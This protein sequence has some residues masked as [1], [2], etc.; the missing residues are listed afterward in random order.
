MVGVVVQ[1]VSIGTLAKELDRNFVVP[2]LGKARHIVINL[3]LFLWGW[4]RVRLSEA[5]KSLQLYTLFH[6]SHNV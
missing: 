2:T 5:L 6:L 3:F 4:E 1:N